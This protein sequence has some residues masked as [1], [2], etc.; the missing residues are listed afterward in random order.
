MSLRSPPPE[1]VE[2]DKGRAPYGAGVALGMCAS[3]LFWSSVLLFV[4]LRS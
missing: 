3:I 4:F 1:L 2:F